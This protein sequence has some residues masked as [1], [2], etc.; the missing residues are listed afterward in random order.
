MRAGEELGRGPELVRPKADH[1]G[2]CFNAPMGGFNLEDVN[3]HHE[4]IFEHSED[5]FKLQ[6]RALRWVMK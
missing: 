3:K 6:V 1:H 4:Q 5:V 2:I